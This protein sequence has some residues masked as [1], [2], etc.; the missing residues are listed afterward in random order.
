MK[1]NR[2]TVRL[3][4]D[5]ADKKWGFSITSVE[6]AT[7]EIIASGECGESLTWTLT[8]L[9]VLTVSGTGMMTDYYESVDQPGAPWGNEILSAFIE[10]GVTSIGARAFAG[11]SSLV[12]VSLPSSLTSIGDW[13]FGQCGSLAEVE[14]PDALTRIG[15]CAFYDCDRLTEMMIP[16]SV[17]MLGMGPFIGCDTLRDLLVAEENTAYC[18]IFGVVYTKNKEEIVVYPS[19]RHDDSYTIQNGTTVIGQAAFAYCGRFLT[20]LYVP[21]SVVGIEGMAF[22]GSSGLTLCADPGSY[23][24]SYANENSI[25]FI[26]SYVWQI[27]DNVL[28]ISGSYIPD[29][30]AEH[31]APWGTDIVEA[32][33]SDE[34]PCIGN[35]AFFG[36]QALTAVSIPDNVT[37]IGEETFTG[38][39]N[40]TI[41]ASRYSYAYQYASQHDIPWAELKDKKD[42]LYV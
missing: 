17:T 10:E 8:G 26:P 6:A 19:G 23:T 1:G 21:A 36:C 35:Y 37:A 2:F 30:T 42:L 34:L 4:S 41:Y 11:C 39:E 20:T 32:V 28:T 13:A 29:F 12:Q 25:P 18:D 14:L 15:G 22:A 38:A 24:E 9:G 5:S 40:V 31:P 3:V 16:A 7:E 27:E 33:I